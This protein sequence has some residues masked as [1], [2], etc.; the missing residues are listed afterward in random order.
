MVF[1][2][3]KPIEIKIISTSDDIKKG[4]CKLKYAFRF[5]IKESSLTETI[6]NEEGQPVEQSTQ[7]WEYEEITDEME[8][9]LYMKPFIPEILKVAYL[10][11]IPI[12]EQNFSL[13]VSNIPSDINI[14]HEEWLKWA[15]TKQS[16]A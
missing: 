11:A 12:L 13:S 14:P 7:G 2:S 4:V 3:E 15:S 8:L 6:Y 5:A 9:P 10:K 16:T 1:S